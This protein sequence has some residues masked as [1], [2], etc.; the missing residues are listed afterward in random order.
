MESAS[1][2]TTPDLIMV[3]D[4]LNIFGMARH[5]VPPKADTPFIIDSYTV[6]TRPCSSQHPFEIVSRWNTQVVKLSRIVDLIQ[7]SMCL[8][9]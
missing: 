5:L 2:M 9:R 1:F 7:L 3:I 8:P 4:N 6:L